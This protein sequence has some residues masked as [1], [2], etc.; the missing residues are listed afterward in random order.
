MLASVVNGQRP[1]LVREF[2][3]IGVFLGWQSVLAI[4]AL[5]LPVY[6][7]LRLVL[8]TGVRWRGAGLWLTLASFS[9][10]IGLPYLAEFLWSP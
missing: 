7:L 2:A 1:T 10:I 5:T 3:M 6:V 8:P 9:W 4:G